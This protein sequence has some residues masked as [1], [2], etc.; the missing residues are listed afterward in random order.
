[1]ANINLLPWREERR[2]ELKK[3]FL[4]ILAI[5]AVAALVLVFI[6]DRI[7]NSRIN[8][9]QER[10]AYLQSSITKLTEQ[11]TEISELETRREDL[12]DRMKIIQDL[13]GNRPVIVRVFDELVRTVPDGLYYNELSRKGDNVAIEGVAESSN[14]VS[15]LMRRLDSSDWFSGPNL[16]GVKANANYGDQGSDFEL[17]VRIDTPVEDSEEDNEGKK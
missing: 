12:L 4:T 17:T 11:V 16:T 5:V 6:A 1:M 8:H 3:E 13:Q 15:S 2:E 9:Q 14:R 7:T 10:N